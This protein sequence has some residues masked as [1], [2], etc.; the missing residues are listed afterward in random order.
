[1]KSTTKSTE[2]TFWN[3]CRHFNVRLDIKKNTYALWNK[4]DVKMAE[5]LT[6]QVWSIKDLLHKCWT[7]VG[8]FV[9]RSGSQSK[10]RIRIICS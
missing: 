2:E 4:C 6:E 8:N 3:V 7:N 5:F 1:M 9:F 10:Q